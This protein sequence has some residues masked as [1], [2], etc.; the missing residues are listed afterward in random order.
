MELLKNT[1]INEHAINLEKGNQ[2]PYKPIYSL[3]LM[4]LETWKTYIK[5]YLKTGLI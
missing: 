4:E 3:G 1:G 2:L 5:T